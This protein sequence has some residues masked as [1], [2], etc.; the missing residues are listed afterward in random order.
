MAI[1]HRGRP[2][3]LKLSQETKNKI[4]LSKTNYIHTEDSKKKIS[5]SLKV[6]FT[7]QKGLQNREQTHLFMSGFWN[8]QE[9]LA[10]RND[11]S[12]KMQQYYKLI[13]K[14]NE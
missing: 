14:E 8:S 2:K 4:A 5:N 1:A 7:T 9:G 13:F 12:I 10:F 6:F 11:L 3:G